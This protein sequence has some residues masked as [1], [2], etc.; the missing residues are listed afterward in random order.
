MVF[1]GGG[2]LVATTA[3]AGAAGADQLAAVVM[4]EMKE[5]EESVWADALLVYRGLR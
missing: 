4:A 3:G 2:L 5:R 1:T